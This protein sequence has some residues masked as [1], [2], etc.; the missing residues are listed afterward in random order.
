MQNIAT[1]TF[2]LLLSACSTPSNEKSTAATPS[3]A[4]K[5]LELDEIGSAFA[6]DKETRIQYLKTAIKER[7]Q[8]LKGVETALLEGQDL[9]ANQLTSEVLVNELLLLEAERFGLEEGLDIPES[10][11]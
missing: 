6:K 9:E 5:T 8:K 11:L 10:D 2:I 1:I 7:S 3:Q 4:S